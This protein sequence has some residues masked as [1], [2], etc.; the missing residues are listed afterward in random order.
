MVEWWD[1]RVRVSG[2][3]SEEATIT[4]S[5][6]LGHG[7]RLRL[8]LS[9]R[10]PLLSNPAPALTKAKANLLHD[11]EDVHYAAPG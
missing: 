1:G 5:L 6:G 3:R 11:Y 2:E 9:V 7:L 8:R 4:P 10:L